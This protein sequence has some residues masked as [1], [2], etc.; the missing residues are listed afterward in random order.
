M[1]ILYF[2]IIFFCNFLFFL[3]KLISALF[4][5][6]PMGPGPVFVYAQ[7]RTMP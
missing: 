4:I 5:D 2:N 1:F 6:W 7:E 3:K